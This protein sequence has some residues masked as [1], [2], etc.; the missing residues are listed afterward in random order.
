M[1]EAMSRAVFHAE[2]C[3]GCGLCVDAC[4]RHIVQI[5]DSFNQAGYAPAGCTDASRCTGCALCA[6]ICPDL[7]IE[8]FRDV[9]DAHA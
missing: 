4:P 5:T 7:A 9:K 2:R 6:L 8:V 1:G 3:K